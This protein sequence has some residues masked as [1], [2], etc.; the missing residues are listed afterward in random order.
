MCQFRAHDRQ[1]CHGMQEIDELKIIGVDQARPPNVSKKTYIDLFFQLSKEA[2]K[3]WC[4]L[5][6]DSTARFQPSIRIDNKKG[7]F[8]DTYVR[9]MEDI[10]AHVEVI[11]QKI[12]ESNA[13]YA[14]KIRQRSLALAAER[15]STSGDEGEQGRLNRIVAELNFGDKSAGLLP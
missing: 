7:L 6:N 9:N 2:P 11:K 15:S 4:D 14:E 5:F 13:I 3:E 10:P 8:I 12:I 1:E